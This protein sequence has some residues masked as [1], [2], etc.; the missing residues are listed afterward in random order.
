MGKALAYALGWW[1]MRTAVLIDGR[2]GV[3]KNLCENAIRPTAIGRNY[4]LFIGAED[5]D[6]RS[7]VIY[8]ITS[9]GA[10]LEAYMGSVDLAIVIVHKLIGDFVFQEGQFFEVQSHPTMLEKNMVVGANDDDILGD[11]RTVMLSKRFEVMPFRIPGDLQIWA[12]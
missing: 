7:A 8:S 3:D 12:R 5:A 4:W 10:R 9:R 2:I 1:P 6:W 11:V